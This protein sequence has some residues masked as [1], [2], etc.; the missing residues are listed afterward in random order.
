TRAL[1]EAAW[2]LAG[3]DGARIDWD[4]VAERFARVGAAV[5]LAGFAVAL[6]DLFGVTVPV[7]RRGGDAWWRAAQALLDRPRLAKRWRA[8]ASVPRALSSERLAARYGATSGA[9]RC[10]A[11]VLHMG[12]AVWKRASREPDRSAAI[13]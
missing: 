3:P 4:E 9:Q 13:R 1:V 2:M 8:V 7:P 6:D 12:R 10:R 5:P 11:R